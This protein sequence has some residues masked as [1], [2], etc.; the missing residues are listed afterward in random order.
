ME[1]TH[2][3]KWN[4]LRRLS[5]SVSARM[6]CTADPVSLFW[7]LE[8][9]VAA[10]WIQPFS[11]LHSL[12]LPDSLREW[13]KVLLFGVVRIFFGACNLRTHRLYCSQHMYFSTKGTASWVFKQR[14]SSFGFYKESFQVQFESDILHFFW[15]LEESKNMFPTHENK[16]GQVS[17]ST[18]KK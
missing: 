7:P 13:S 17:G 18:L 9:I 3:R 4:S 15:R 8:V 16:N 12:V 5:F 1:W 11:P 2:A 14:Y 10:R 6:P